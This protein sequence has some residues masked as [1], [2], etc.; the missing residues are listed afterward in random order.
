MT[1]I[2]GDFSTT[3]GIWIAAFLTLSI[4]SFLY[5]DNPFY[6]IAEH[7]IVGV[8]V[9][10]ILS[11]QYRDAFI[12]LVWKPL[13]KNGEYFVII[14]T[15]LGI[16]ML[17]RFIPKYSWIS[18]YPIAFTIGLG[19]GVAIAPEMQARILKQLQT[20]MVTYTPGGPVPWNGIIIFIGVLS[21]LAYFFFS[22]PHKGVLGV[23]AQMGLWFLMVGFGASFG[24]TVMARITLFIGRAH[25]LLSDWLKII[26]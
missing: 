23:S 9:G 21:G 26:E 14:P 2:W 7:L 17:L 16:M 5:K 22:K 4:Y 19:S 11:V 3:L 12:P 24:Y 15:V 18:R 1:T 10:Y 13:F 6:K 20:T 25:F 8:S